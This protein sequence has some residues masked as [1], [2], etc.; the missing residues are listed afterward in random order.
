MGNK[1]GKHG[2]L[3]IRTDQP[4]YIAGGVVTGNVFVDCRAPFKGSQLMLVIEG[5]AHD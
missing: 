4:Y 5:N 3:L 2:T 1:S